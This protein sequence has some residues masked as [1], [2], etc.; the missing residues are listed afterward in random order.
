MVHIY[1][2]KYLEQKCFALEFLSEVKGKIK[3]E[4]MIMKRQQVYGKCIVLW[5]DILAQL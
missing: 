1:R 5:Y 2:T 3:C 4:E